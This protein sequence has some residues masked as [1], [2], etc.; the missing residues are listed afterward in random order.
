MPFF[1]RHA[2]Q[3]PLARRYSVVGSY[4][5]SLLWRVWLAIEAFTNSYPLSTREQSRAPS[6]RQ[7]N[8]VLAVISTMGPSDSPIWLSASFHGG[9]AYRNGYCRRRLQTRRGLPS[10]QVNSPDIPLPLR[11]R[12]LW[13]CIF[14]LFTPSV[15]FTLMLR[16][17]LPLEPFR[18]THYDA[19]GF[20]SCY[21]LSGRDDTAS[22]L[23]LLLTP[24][25][26][27]RA[28]CPLP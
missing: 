4:R 1:R 26:R 10:S 3:Q 6:L 9:S 25:G 13:R 19:A 18:G 20:T 7:G 15:A 23:G 8:V 2:G 27:Y 12:V 14:R 11:R 24:G 21:G 5:A 17:R 28:A 22:T 16:V